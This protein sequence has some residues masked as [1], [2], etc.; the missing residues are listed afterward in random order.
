MMIPE[1][2]R[3]ISPG[4]AFAS[5]MRPWMRRSSGWRAISGDKGRQFRA[6]YEMLRKSV[7]H[8]SLF[9]LLLLHCHCQIP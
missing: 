9:A 2:R 6:V 8:A 1:W 4:F 5:T 7:A 3:A